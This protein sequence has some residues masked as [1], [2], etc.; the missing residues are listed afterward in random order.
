M[1]RSARG[2]APFENRLAIG[3][4]HLQAVDHHQRFDLDIEL[5]PPKLQHVWSVRMLEEELAGEF[6]IFFIEGAAGDQD[7]DAF[8]GHSS[9]SRP[10]AERAWSPV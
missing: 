4:R 6:V 10:G 9:F 2:Q 1:R 7:A 5:A 8:E 3:R